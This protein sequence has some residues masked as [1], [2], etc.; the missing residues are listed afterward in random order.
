MYEI[1]DFFNQTF[2]GMDLGT[3]FPA[4]VNLVSDILAEDGIS[5]NFFYSVRFPITETMHIV[6]DEKI[7]GLHFE[8]V[9]IMFHNSILG[10]KQYIEKN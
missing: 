3:L 2:L 4:R 1:L 9:K 5:Q 10:K 6:Q 7:M 8:Y